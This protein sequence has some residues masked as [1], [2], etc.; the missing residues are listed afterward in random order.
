VSVAPR[1]WARWKSPRLPPTSITVTRMLK[2]RP[3]LAGGRSSLSMIWSG[4]LG[5]EA[6]RGVQ[7]ESERDAFERG[8]RGH[9]R[10]QGQVRTGRSERSSEPP[11]LAR[12]RKRRSPRVLLIR[13][14]R[15]P[16]HPALRRYPDELQ[17]LPGQ[18][19]V[20]PAPW[21][22]PGQPESSQDAETSASGS[23]VGSQSPVS[24]RRSRCNREHAFGG[25]RPGVPTGS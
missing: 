17:L 21:Y 24:Q 25:T 22:A 9:G 10:R 1:R 19:L 2:P 12:R 11:S 20:G 5:L 4:P 16:R 8:R 7:R 3:F 23:Q 15:K 6:Q 14:G 13:V 18:R